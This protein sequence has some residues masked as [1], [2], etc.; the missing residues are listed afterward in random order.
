MRTQKKYYILILCTKGGDGSVQRM[1]EE[2][3]EA[4]KFDINKQC[5][6][7]RKH[8]LITNKYC[9]RTLTRADSS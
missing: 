8:K 7:W 2:E 4:K 9:T 3:E 1:Y 5:N 6:E